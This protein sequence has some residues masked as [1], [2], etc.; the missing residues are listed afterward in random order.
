ML[1]FT[2]QQPDA[3]NSTLM[4]RNENPNTD[5]TDVGLM[6]ANVLFGVSQKNS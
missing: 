6:N 4:D 3:I 1:A 2:G 5:S